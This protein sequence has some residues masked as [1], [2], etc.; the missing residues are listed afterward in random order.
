MVEDVIASEAV[1]QETCTTT[2]ACATGAA[3]A[4]AGMAVGMCMSA[5]T[6]PSACACTCTVVGEGDS[7]YK[8]KSERKSDDG[9]DDGC[10]CPGGLECM[11]EDS[12]RCATKT[13]LA[14][15]PLKRIHVFSFQTDYTTY[16]TNT[17]YSQHPDPKWDMS[18]G[19]SK[20]EWGKGDKR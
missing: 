19:T 8:G 10:T 2:D 3:N 13:H 15:S 4:T 12:L 16:V 18:S 5:R 14:H 17:I 1:A 7:G 9:C 6:T 11:F 20:R